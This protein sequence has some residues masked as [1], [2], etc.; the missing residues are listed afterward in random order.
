MQESY[1]GKVKRKLE[2]AKNEV[3]KEGGHQLK[4]RG[5]WTICLRC[6]ARARNGNY[7][8]WSRSSCYRPM[9]KQKKDTDVELGKAGNTLSNCMDGGECVVCGNEYDMLAYK[10]E[11]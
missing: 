2:E 7:G 8:Y 3:D 1:R 6:T 4:V 9:K 5:D 10:C 11:T